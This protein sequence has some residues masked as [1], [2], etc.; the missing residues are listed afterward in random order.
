[1]S[2]S[3]KTTS[4]KTAKPVSKWNYIL[5]ASVSVLVLVALTLGAFSPISPQAWEEVS[6]A[7][8]ALPVDQATPGAISFIEWGYFRLFPYDIALTLTS[9]TARLCVALMGWLMYFFLSGLLRILSIRGLRDR[10]R[11]TIAIRLSAF[12]GS[13]LFVFSP[14]VYQSGLALLGS[15]GLLLWTV[16]ALF[17]TMRFIRQASILA[18]SFAL[19]SYGFLIGETPIGLALLGL[20]VFATV[21]WHNRGR[22]QA[23]GHFLDPIRLQHSKWQ[24]TFAFLGGCFLGFA[25]AIF[26]YLLRGGL[27]GVGGYIS[28]WLGTFLK[29]LDKIPLLI[30]ALATLL[31]LVPAF[32]LLKRATDEERFLPFRIGVTYIFILVVGLIQLASFQGLHYWEFFTGVRFDYQ[33]LL[34]LSPILSLLAAVLGIY[35]FFVEMLCR[36]YRYLETGAVAGRDD[37]EGDDTID[38]SRQFV[39]SVRLGARWIPILFV[40]LALLG[41]TVMGPRFSADRAVQRVLYSYVQFA[42]KDL[43]GVDVLFTDGALDVPLRLE[44]HRQGQ[45]LATVSFTGGPSAR[46]AALRRAAARTPE[47]YV[48]LE[49]G[50]VAALREWTE[51]RPTAL[52]GAAVQCGYEVFSLNSSLKPIAYATHVRPVGGDEKDAA[53]SFEKVKKIAEDFLAEHANGHW[54]HVKTAFLREAFLVA[55]FRMAVMMRLRARAL[56]PSPEADELEALARRLDAANPSLQKLLASVLQVRQLNAKHLTLRETLALALERANFA[57]ARE[58]ATE[59]LKNDPKNVEARFALGMDA[60]QLGRWVAAESYLRAALEDAPDEPALHNNL[61]L[62]LLAINRLDDAAAEVARARALMPDS[63]EIKATEE[64]VSEAQKAAERARLQKKQSL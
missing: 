51:D 39:S 21:L 49:L 36:D 2:D 4:V 7:V 5:A 59:I 45:K 34:P 61:A 13:L 30:Y 10:A 19:I 48:A 26:S 42:V 29:S 3:V 50:A 38:P 64:E 1:M 63:A 11:R 43:A 9:W 56:A 46:A 22:R 53:E 40:S 57:M 58:A 31:P 28:A 23:W 41:V 27:G 12:F 55:Q 25:V 47:D 62:V 37:A 44:A 54:A 17:F 14:F 15:T 35:V 52:K 8:G 16:A 60:Y 18:A 33:I 24:L 32:I 6:Y 20:G